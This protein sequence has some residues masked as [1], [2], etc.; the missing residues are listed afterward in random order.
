MEE[1]N[2]LL[3]RLTP[4]QRYAEISHLTRRLGGERVLVNL[5]RNTAMRGDVTV[6]LSPSQTVIMH[7]LCAAYP[8]VVSVGE[9]A[10]ALWGPQSLH[11][12]LNTVRVMITAMRRRIAPLQAS[13]ENKFSKGYRL[14]LA[15]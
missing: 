10:S 14:E 6:E 4:E 3:Q 12:D 13:I 1:L 8:F 15:L 11:K 9:I 5:D 2:M 7:K